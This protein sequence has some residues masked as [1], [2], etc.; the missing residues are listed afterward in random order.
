MMSDKT[1]VFV[2]EKP[3]LE[4]DAD[5]KRQ[6]VHVHAQYPH[7]AYSIMLS[8]HENISTAEQLRLALLELKMKLMQ[9]ILNAELVTQNNLAVLKAKDIDVN[10]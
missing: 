3:S 7:F 9:E 5:L 2:L 6:I 10:E 1:F 8:P 4:P